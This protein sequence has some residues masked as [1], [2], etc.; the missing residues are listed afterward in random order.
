MGVASAGLLLWSG[1]II[2]PL[3]DPGKDEGGGKDVAIA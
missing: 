2:L 3:F 1:A